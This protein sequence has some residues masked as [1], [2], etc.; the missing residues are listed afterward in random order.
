M[1]IRVSCAAALFLLVAPVSGQ[2]PDINDFFR[3]FTA[4][5]VRSSPNL[6]TS[7]RYFTGEEQERLER[8]LTPETLAYRRARIELA[9]KGLAELGKFD[10]SKL[11]EIQRVSADLMAWQLD[12]VVREEPFLD[13]SFPLQQMS[14]ANVNLVEVLT[15][16]HPVANEKDA[17]NY[18]A[19]LGQVGTRMDEATA[20]AHRLAAK[21]VIPPKFILQATIKQMSSFIDQPAAQ[22]PFAAIFTQKLDAIKGWNP[23]R[24]NEL[25]AQAAK[26]VE[27][28]VYPSWKRGIA[29][30]QSQLPRSNDDAGL[31]RLKGGADAYAYFLNR[32][33]TTHLTAAQIHEI[34][35]REVDR[36]EK[37]MDTILRRLGRT[38]GSVKDRVEKLKADL[39]YP[40]TEQGRELIMVDVRNILR[41]AQ[42][43]S[44]SLFDKVP[45]SP[46]VA[47]PFPRFRE[48]NAAANYNAP[49]PDGSRPGTFQ[50]PLRPDR[51]TK[52]GLRSLVYHET[53]PGH[54]FQ[55][56]LQVENKELPRFRQIGAFG[57]IS[58]LSE[59]WGLYAERLAAESG[60]YDG[61]PEGLLGQLDA[62][63]FRARRLVVDTGL[64]AQ[65]WTRQQGIDYGIE[66]SEV[67]RYVVFPGQACSY[68]IGQLK[69]V[70]LREK[71][72]KALGD[73]FSLRTF[74]D[75]VLNTG[76]VPLNLLEQQ[77][78]AYIRA[79]GGKL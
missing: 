18:L 63:L 51:M 59:G 27:T 11:T 56:A 66:T 78:D 79:N 20:E 14:G 62:A 70:E 69:I 22:N 1:T 23:A 57:G 48:D 53:V 2:Q 61:D 34:G 30:L 25:S 12:T 40:K 42:R 13:Y 74:H 45:K 28:E 9:R 8:E 73:K 10:R 54:H 41:D 76:T 64:H 3:N 37:E 77:V 39:G 71:A 46:V 31:W 33:T 24:R 4:E 36:I 44:D 52:F 21:N 35:L 15:V 60:W 72:K 58:A 47:Q 26:L 6:A 16:R 32:Y 50:I 17:G 7:S 55:I 65:H 49:A 75:V 67:E 38:Q 68:M 43:R 19:A 29:E 5:W